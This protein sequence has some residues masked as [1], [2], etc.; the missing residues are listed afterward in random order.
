MVKKNVIMGER[1]YSE[2]EKNMCFI[3]VKLKSHTM[4]RN[5]VNCLADELDIQTFIFY[6]G[7]QVKKS[8]SLCLYLQQQAKR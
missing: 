4:K 1:Q 7:W 5:D 6:C 8:F 2:E 3:P